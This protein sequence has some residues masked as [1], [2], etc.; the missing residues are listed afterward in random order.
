MSLVRS[1]FCATPDH[2]ITF[3]SLQR[4]I[5]GW[6]QLT[7]DPPQW[8][9][10][11]HS[12]V[13]ELPSVVKFL[14]G[15]FTEQPEDYVPYIEYKVPLKIYQ[16]IGAGRDTDQHLLPLNRFWLDHRAA[17]GK[18][19]MPEGRLSKAAAIGG[20]SVDEESIPA[21]RSP[22]NWV[23]RPERAEEVAMFQVQER[24]RYENPNSPFT[25]RL[26]GYEATVGPVTG[27]FT[28]VLNKGANLLLP[29]RPASATMLSLVR[30]AI[31]RLPNGEGTKAHVSEL[32][33]ASQYIQPG[34]VLHVIVTAVVERLQ[35]EG[36]VHFDQRRKTI[37]YTHR[38][39]SEI[40]FKKPQVMQQQ[41]KV[42]VKKADVAGGKLMTRVVSG[43]RL[44]GSGVAAGQKEAVSPVNVRTAGGAATGQ[45]NV[46]QIRTSKVSAT[47]PTTTTTVMSRNS[48]VNVTRVVT[49][50]A[51]GGSGDLPKDIEMCLDAK[52]P[53]ALIPKLTYNKTAMK[54][55]SNAESSMAQSRPAA[56]MS[57]LT[58][59]V[60][61]QS[62]LMP[63]QTRTIK[64]TAAGTS[65]TMIVSSTNPPALVAASG[66][67]GNKTLVSRG[68]PVAVLPAN[69]KVVRA[70]SV[71]QAQVT[72]VP[73]KTITVS[74]ATIAAAVK[75]QK[76]IQINTSTGNVTTAN[77]TVLR[78]GSTNLLAKPVIQNIVIRSGSPQS[79]G[80]I[81]RTVPLKS[82]TSVEGAVNQGTATS[83]LKSIILPK[84]DPGGGGSVMATGQNVIKIR[85]AGPNQGQ[86]GAAKTITA[87][88]ATQFLQLQP[89]SSGSSGQQ[90][91]LNSVRPANSNSQQQGT[92]NLPNSIAVKT[93]TLKQTTSSA[94]LV[95][96]PPKTI[97]KSSQMATRVLKTIPSSSPGT[98]PGVSPGQSIVRT[99]SRVVGTAGSAGQLVTLVDGKGS[100][101]TA[102]ATPIRLTK[103]GGTTN[104]IQL[105]ATNGAGSP[106]TQYTVLSPGRS[107]IQ[108]QQQ[109]QHGAGKASTESHGGQTARLLNAKVVSQGGVVGDGSATV[110]V[111]P[112]IR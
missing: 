87:P 111:K 42:I 28:Q 9:G 69:T 46:F 64:V 99:V 58:S 13:S 17:F 79:A 106:G 27:V 81:K 110:T 31:A 21:S 68:S 56:V 24:Q 93:T 85:T 72:V 34:S 3:D 107:V 11:C 14:V 96:L 18:P 23:M 61:G 25:Y 95:Q 104:V 75:A 109:Q 92:V 26:H 47:T 6:L 29:D 80:T 12:W 73:K 37:I 45:G 65:Q 102:N 108:V 63:N 60:A 112:G 89:G 59:S 82:F 39:K 54:V 52:Q 32:L 77:G 70:S 15:E 57:I 50:R 83:S 100:G 40:D 101:Q 90:F 66:M 88:G 44:S 38:S 97:F 103:S 84:S 19:A 2:R 55:A 30:D 86:Q 76:P 67:A 16:W 91:F 74:P 8:L 78:A 5:R 36:S 51:S 10:D 94:Q 20:D 4:A 53:P 22:T 48:P 98:S 7:K 33:K 41:K 43:S 105:S 62:V 71:G 1:I 49:M 35:K